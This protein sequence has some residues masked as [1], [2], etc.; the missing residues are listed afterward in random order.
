MIWA[1]IIFI[2]A[3]IGGWL[4]RMCGGAPPKLRWGLE[5]WVYALPYLV[6]SLPV[7]TAL[8]VVLSVK[9]DN[10]RY[11][12]A[13][14][15]LPFLGAVA[16]KRTGHGNA[17]DLGRLPHPADDEQLEFLIKPL[18]GKISDYWYDV[19]LMAVTGLATTLVTGLLFLFYAPFYGLL[20]LLSGLMKGPSY[21]GGW[22]I[23]PNGS[24]KGIPYLNE[25]TAIGEFLTGFFAYAALGAAIRASIFTMFNI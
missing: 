13:I 10:R 4:S 14:A 11:F 9:K 16:G 18:F 5:Q 2:F 8:A 7:T 21:M 25:A 1:V 15:L 12:K 6:V 17:L 3:L 22:A 19:L 23:Y 24:G 20:I